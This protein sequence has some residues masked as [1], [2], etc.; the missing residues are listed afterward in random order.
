[1]TDLTYD[2]YLKHYG[3]KGMRW[4]VRR[5]EGPDGNVGSGGGGVESKDE[6]KMAGS[7]R[8]ERRA[9]KKQAKTEVK[10]AKQNLRSKEREARSRIRNR[11]SVEKQ[12]RDQKHLSAITEIAAKEEESLVMVTSPQNTPMIVTGREFTKHVSRGGMLDV[13]TTQLVASNQSDYQNQH[14]R[15]AYD[16]SDAVAIA[17]LKEKHQAARENYKSAKKRR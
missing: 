1:M 2:N 7:S 14:S 8:G 13:K 11:T 3:I 16:E 10:T 9:A 12:E 5:E 6:S 4:G 17:D 15:M